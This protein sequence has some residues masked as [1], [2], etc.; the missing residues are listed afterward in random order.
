MANNLENPDS[1]ANDYYS[2]QSLPASVSD[3]DVAHGSAKD[4]Y[5][6]D[7]V[8]TRGYATREPFVWQ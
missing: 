6:A 8:F 1:P 4:D 3:V 7:A 5:S 2:P